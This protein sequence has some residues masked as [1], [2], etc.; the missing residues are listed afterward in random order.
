MGGNGFCFDGTCLVRR[1]RQLVLA[2]GRTQTETSP[3]PALS[4]RLGG[5]EPAHMGSY[6]R[7]VMKM[8]MVPREIVPRWTDTSTMLENCLTKTI[9]I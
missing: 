6:Q 9:V 5:S 3:Q 2:C 8:S 7:L 1:L 4:V